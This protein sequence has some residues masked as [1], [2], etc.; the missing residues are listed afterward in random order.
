MLLVRSYDNRLMC[1]GYSK[2]NR[3]ML[4]FE[5]L[6]TTVL[7]TQLAEIYCLLQHISASYD[8]VKLFSCRLRSAL[9]LTEHMLQQN[10]IRLIFGFLIFN[11]N[12]VPGSLVTWRS[13][14]PLVTVYFYNHNGIH[15][16]QT[17]LTALIPRSSGWAAT[18]NIQFLLSSRHHIRYHCQPLHFPPI[19]YLH[20]P[21]STVS[22]GSMCQKKSYS[23]HLV[24]L[25]DKLCKATQ[26]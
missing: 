22:L 9:P 8:A 13:P 6:Y 21:R 26:V 12:S 19:S 20:L 10:C 15:I 7:C 4:V 5:T 17:R 11:L 18:R 23:L 1:Q 24:T 2:I 16:K 3:I 25:K 14:A